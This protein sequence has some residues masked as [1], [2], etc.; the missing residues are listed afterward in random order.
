LILNGSPSEGVNDSLSPNAVSP[1]NS[2]G[3]IVGL[4]TSKRSPDYSARFVISVRT[5]I[6]NSVDDS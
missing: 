5:L 3:R 2:V 4:V 6:T 1:P